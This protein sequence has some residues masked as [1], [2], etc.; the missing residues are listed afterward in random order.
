MDKRAKK[1]EKDIISMMQFADMQQISTG[2]IVCD[3]KFKP[4][5]YN[6]IYLSY[7]LP[8]KKI[9][10]HGYYGNDVKLI[11]VTK[12]NKVIPKN[13]KY[14]YQALQFIHQVL[15]PKYLKVAERKMKE[16]QTLAFLKEK[17]L[18]I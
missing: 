17:G 4:F 15:R 1:L 10:L 2:S 3:K 5:N 12:N 13:S 14:Y 9:I 6:N 16:E 7:V 11:I 8:H 18:P